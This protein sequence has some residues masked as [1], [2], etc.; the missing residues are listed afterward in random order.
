M[1]IKL[2]FNLKNKW[3]DLEKN[4]YARLFDMRKVLI[5]ILLKLLS[6]NLVILNKKQEI[7]I[8]FTNF[9][10]GSTVLSH[11]FLVWLIGFFYDEE[12]FFDY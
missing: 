10:D 8:P 2:E 1:E 11:G 6:K 12:V 3:I 5:S 7:V 4:T 9:W